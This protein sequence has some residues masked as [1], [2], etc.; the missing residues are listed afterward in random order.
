LP[1]ERLRQH[2]DDHNQRGAYDIWI[3]HW[4]PPQAPRTLFVLTISRA[5]V[6]SLYIF[7]FLLSI[8]KQVFDTIRKDGDLR[9]R[10]RGG[11]K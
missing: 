7:L 11:Y 6:F 5:G 4:P 1:G 9:R 2:Q 3:P 8:V 10:F